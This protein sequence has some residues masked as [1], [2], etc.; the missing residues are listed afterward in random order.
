[1]NQL[2][3]DFNNKTQHIALIAGIYMFAGRQNEMG[4]F[5]GI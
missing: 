5:S 3:K 2:I 1:M 4:G